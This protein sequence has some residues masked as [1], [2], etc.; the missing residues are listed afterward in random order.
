MS[1][2]RVL[3]ALATMLAVAGTAASTGL[4]RPLS[5]A[6]A[7]ARAHV[8]TASALPPA[9]PALNATT[10]PLLPEAQAIMRRPAS[11]WVRAQALRDL[12]RA[13]VTGTCAIVA[14]AFWRLSLNVGLPIRR[15]QLTANGR[16][17]YDTHMT[18]EV[19]LPGWRIWAIDDAFF[20]G[21]WSDTRS[22]HPTRPVPAAVVH[23]A[24]RAGK[25]SGLS[26]HDAG[27]PLGVSALSWYVDPRALFWIAYYPMYVDGHDWP[28]F[29][30]TRPA[31][32]AVEGTYVTTG[33]L[34]A[35]S[36]S[37]TLPVTAVQLATPSQAVRATPTS[38]PPYARKL[39]SRRRVTL[40]G[41]SGSWSYAGGRSTFVVVRGA[42]GRWLLTVHGSPSPLDEIAG[43][44]LSAISS[45]SGQ[46]TVA[47]RGATPGAAYT[48][49]VWSART[50]PASAVA[51]AR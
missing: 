12:V 14:D 2:R 45:E 7:A 6:G 3:L 23:S 34:L 35:A 4:A 15:V 26:W 19:W 17:A 11:T 49:E 31:D 28:S 46:A 1:L 9:V 25:L 29:V 18:T 50:M 44:H 41:A 40:A 48:I 8:S 22:A 10:E 37:R 16:N 13:H 20:G 27:S 5:A 38:P 32:V 42:G 39:L 47:V 36:P 51:A 43:V 30:V 24:V 21:W 33:D